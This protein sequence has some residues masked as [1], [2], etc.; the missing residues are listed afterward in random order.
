MGLKWKMDGKAYGCVEN[1]LM[2]NDCVPQLEATESWEDAIDDIVT[3]FE[4]QHRRKL[5]YSISFY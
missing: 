1:L 5:V 4:R 3:A 2:Y